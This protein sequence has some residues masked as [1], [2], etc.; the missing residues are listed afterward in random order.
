MILNG[1]KSHFTSYVHYYELS[2]TNYLLLIY[3]SLFITRMTKAC[4]QRRSTGSGIA[5][6]DPHNIG[7]H[8]KSA[9]LPWTL[10]YIVGTL[11]NNVNI[12]I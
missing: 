11:T 4:D 10:G 9:D 1:L 2:Q 8:G 5:K 3:C 12:I 6:S 7:I